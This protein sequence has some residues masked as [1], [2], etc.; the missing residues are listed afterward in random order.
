MRD[1]TLDVLRKHNLDKKTAAYV[2]DTCSVMKA[3][4]KLLMAELPLLMCFGCQAHV[5]SLFL[6]DIC[7]LPDVSSAPLAKICNSDYYLPM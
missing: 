3:A 2:T 7:D 4:W 5:W 6:K 1:K